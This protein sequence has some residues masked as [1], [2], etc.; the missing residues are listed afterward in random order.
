MSSVTSP[1][2]DVKSELKTEQD[3]SKFRSAIAAARASFAAAPPKHFQNEEEL[4]KH[5]EAFAA[6]FQAPVV[7]G[8]KAAKV[9]PNK[10]PDAE[11]IKFVRKFFSSGERSI[12]VRN[13][14]FKRR[15]IHEAAAFLI[16]TEGFKISHESHGIGYTRCLVLRN[17]LMVPEKEKAEKEKD[18]AN[19]CGCLAEDPKYCICKE[20]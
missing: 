8:A 12:E 2:I 18:M 15:Q 6:P 17:L 13:N 20:F 3:L 1:W 11:A 16:S 10:G 14:S 5:V 9:Y 19:E 7:E 4:F